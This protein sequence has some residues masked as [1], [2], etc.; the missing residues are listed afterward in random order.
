LTHRRRSVYPPAYAVTR[1]RGRSLQGNERRL[2]RLER[3]DDAPPILLRSPSAK[4]SAPRDRI[5]TISAFLT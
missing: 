2:F 3:S 1:N 4:R 5:H